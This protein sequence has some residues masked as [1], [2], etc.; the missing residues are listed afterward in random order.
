MGGAGYSGP[1]LKRSQ[2]L[3]DDI[4]HPI[5]PPRVVYETKW[6]WPEEGVRQSSPNHE[7]GAWNNEAVR[8][9]LHG[10]PKEFERA[11]E[12]LLN[13]YYPRE[14]GYSE[15]GIGIGANELICPDNHTHQHLNGVAMGRIAAVISQDEELLDKSEK[16]MQAW[17]S[18]LT[19]LATP[20]PDYF[21]G[22]AGFR[23][24]H[25]P[26]WY[27][28]TSFLRQVM[29]QPGP[30]PEFERKKERWMDLASAPIRAIRWLQ[31]PVICPKCGLSLISP[32]CSSCHDF[33][34]DSPSG[35]ALGLKEGFKNFTHSHSD[36][37]KM[38][39]TIQVYRKTGA[40]HLVVIPRPD[41][42]VKGVCDWVEVPHG[43]HNFK[44]TM[45]AMRFGLNWET[46]VPDPPKGAK[47]YEFPVTWSKR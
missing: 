37:P 40:R 35:H 13:A 46:L 30:M 17:V 39:T 8:A 1:V 12:V 44:K 43:I 45:E 2:L 10:T 16:L 38:K 26:Y 4:H 29:G 36:L 14:L 23:S 6:A 33:L 5:S 28:G 22:S 47:M 11:K 42:D 9:A 34:L 21:V 41:F 15:K 25:K 27:Y 18:M 20:G 24:P 7:A 19:V 31:N 32:S 3:L